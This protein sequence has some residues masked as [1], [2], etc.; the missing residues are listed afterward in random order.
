ML[1]VLVESS[2]FFQKIRSLKRVE[3]FASRVVIRTTIEGFLMRNVWSVN[4]TCFAHSLRLYEILLT[5]LL[6]FY[7]FSLFNRKQHDWFEQQY[8]NF[9][10]VLLYL[11]FRMCCVSRET[12]KLGTLVSIV[13]IWSEK[14]WQKVLYLCTVNN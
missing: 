11:S 5:C 12:L 6:K 2:V 3:I 1:S 7:L 10:F 4:G 8:V 9:L 14:S 13:S